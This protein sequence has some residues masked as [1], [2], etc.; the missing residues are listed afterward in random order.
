MWAHSISLALGVVFRFKIKEKWKI[1]ECCLLNPLNEHW[2]RLEPDRIVTTVSY[3]RNSILTK[4]VVYPELELQTL[5][6]L[7][8]FRD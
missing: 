7:Q 1:V 8:F 4:T 5:Q 6:F 2:L 3:N